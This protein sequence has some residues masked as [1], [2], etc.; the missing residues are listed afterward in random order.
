MSSLAHRKVAAGRLSVSHH[1]A[2]VF[3]EQYRVFLCGK[4]WKKNPS[5]SQVLIISFDMVRHHAYMYPQHISY[6]TKCLVMLD[7]SPITSRETG[8]SDLS[9][10]QHIDRIVT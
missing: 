7:Q 10:W 1:M 3:F 2:S 4:Y 8:T 5:P 9:A 6:Q